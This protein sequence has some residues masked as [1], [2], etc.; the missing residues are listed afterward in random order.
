MTVAVTTEITLT[1]DEE[2]VLATR[3]EL[4]EHHRSLGA[5]VFECM[6]TEVGYPFKAI[7]KTQLLIG[8]KDSGLE[9]VKNAIRNQ[10]YLLDSSFDCISK[11]EFYAIRHLPHHA[12]DGT[13]M[14]NHVNMVLAR[15]KSINVDDLPDD[16]RFDCDKIKKHLEAHYA[17]MMNDSEAKQGE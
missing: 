10:D 16:L 6:R 2:G 7:L 5:I 1:G 11:K 4:I 17:E 15:I 8:D 13:L 12:P 9:V 14:P 3:D